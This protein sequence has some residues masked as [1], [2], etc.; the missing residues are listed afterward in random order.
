MPSARA[1]GYLRADMSTSRL[2]R[3]LAAVA[4]GEV[5]VPRHFT[6]DLVDELQQRDRLRDLVAARTA[7]PLTTR[8]WEVLRLLGDSRRTGEIAALFGISEVTVRRHVSALLG[9]LGLRDRASAVRLL[10]SAA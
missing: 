8:E 2:T 1:R 7:A 10:R 5:A 9:K 4:Q 3:V 6:V